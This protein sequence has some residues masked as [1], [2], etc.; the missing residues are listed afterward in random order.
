MG[1]EKNFGVFKKKKITCFDANKK[2]I[3]R[4]HRVDNL[5]Q[6]LIILFFFWQRALFCSSF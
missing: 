5:M 3:K 4:V 6:R 1:E 2:N